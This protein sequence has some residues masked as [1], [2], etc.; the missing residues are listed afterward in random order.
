MW[1]DCWAR[2]EKYCGVMLEV[3]SSSSSLLPSAGHPRLLIP[4]LHRR[5]GQ[6]EYISFM[7]QSLIQ[8]EVA[9]CFLCEMIVG[10]D[11]INNGPDGGR[12]SNPPNK[13]VDCL[14]LPP[15]LG[16]PLRRIFQQPCPKSK[17]EPSNTIFYP[18]RSPIETSINPIRN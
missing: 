1:N 13:V 3:T 6:F 16:P 15:T 5:Y 18:Y 11:W 7:L 10:Y 17:T 8:H 4:S 9:V 14:H 2:L 12:D